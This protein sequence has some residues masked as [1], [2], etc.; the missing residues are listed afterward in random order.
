MWRDSRGMWG[1]G[2][3]IVS[4][5]LRRRGKG[6]V[7]GNSYLDKQGSMETFFQVKQVDF[8]MLGCS[9]G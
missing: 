4:G 8:V 7:K 9:G 3:R 6:G 5:G 2:A 1:D